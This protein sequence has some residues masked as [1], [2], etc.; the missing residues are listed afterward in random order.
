[1]KT[2]HTCCARGTRVRV[3]LRNGDVIVDRFVERT[4]KFVVLAKHRI[5]GG[6]LKS[7]GIY[8]GASR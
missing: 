4:G 8:K 2:P 3:V 1:M 6:E 5:R 7:F